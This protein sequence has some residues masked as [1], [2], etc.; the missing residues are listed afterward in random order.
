MKK[1]QLIQR[2]SNQKPSNEKNQENAT[3]SPLN[4]TFTRTY[5]CYNAMEEMS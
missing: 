4:L 3:N 2:E 5:T 1:T